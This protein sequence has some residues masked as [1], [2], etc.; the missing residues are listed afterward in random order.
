MTS[1]I[2]INKNDKNKIN[3]INRL[4][5]EEKKQIEENSKIIINNLR[6][7][8]TNEQPNEKKDII[9]NNFDESLNVFLYEFF[10]F[11]L[12]T[13]K[14][15]L[16]T[17]RQPILAFRLLDFPTLSIEGRLNA[18]KNLVIF[19]QGKSSFFEMELRILKDYLSNEPLYVMFID[20][21]HGDIRIIGSSRLNIS[22]F[23]NEHFL[24]QNTN[25]L[26]KSTPKPRRN[27][28]KLF[29]KC[30]TVVAEFDISLL[31]KRE[32]FN[33]HSKKEILDR[34]NIDVNK[35]SNPKYLNC[36]NNCNDS[37]NNASTLNYEKKI[38]S[39]YNNMQ[40]Y[41][42]SDF[43]NI[44]DN[45]NNQKFNNENLVS[46]SHN[47]HF[48]SNE[49]KFNNYNFQGGNPNCIDEE[50]VDE[51]IHYNYNQGKTINGNLVKLSPFYESNTINI[52][53]SSNKFQSQ[54]HF[55]TTTPNQNDINKNLNG[56]QSPA[57]KSIY[58][59]NKENIQGLL[60]PSQGKSF[61][62]HLKD[63]LD[64]SNKHPSPLYFNNKIRNAEEEFFIASPKSEVLI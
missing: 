40:F 12:Y 1:S 44:C 10:V 59:P 22:I 16:K 60:N 30:Q 15:I 52:N 56:K 35:N 19:N 2:N 26:H 32:F 9:H 31:I 64:G 33:Y 61:V 20:L 46:Q 4:Q 29:D 57:A 13:P 28:L 23:D 7:E 25:N 39:G 37:I 21:N 11:E 18:Q 36:K 34:L 5:A 62:R 58:N 38:N 49:E 53:H 51:F 14:E 54:S 24:E 63:L 27:L 6:N 48:Y 42:Q 8:I 43:N 47:K 41:L 50:A 17:L 45:F 3:T 55:L